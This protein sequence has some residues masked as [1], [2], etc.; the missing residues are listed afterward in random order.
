M[1]FIIHKLLGFFLAVL[2][3]QETIILSQHSVALTLSLR[4]ILVLNL[5][6]C[7]Y[8]QPHTTEGSKQS[9]AG[10]GTHRWWGCIEVHGWIRGV[11]KWEK[12]WQLHRQGT[13]FL[14][15]SG[16]L[17]CAWRTGSKVSLQNY[18][19]SMDA[20]NSS[21]VP[22]NKWDSSLV[23]PGILWAIITLTTCPV[24]KF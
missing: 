13:Y 9:R 12:S 23:E 19:L 14:L 15:S 5:Q 24:M 6:F 3:C 11:N 18:S 20:N 10:H 22:G 1:T 2:L 8:S 7:G 17:L 4:Q 16:A 21:A